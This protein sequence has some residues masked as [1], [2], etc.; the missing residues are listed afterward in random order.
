MFGRLHC[1]EPYLGGNNV[2]LSNIGQKEI[3]RLAQMGRC[4]RLD[5]DVELVLDV[6]AR[7][8]VMLIDCAHGA[9]L[10]HNVAPYPLY[11]IL[12]PATLSPLPL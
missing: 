9:T 1:F 5:D 7:S 12:L 2:L 3:N 6:V 10:N 4:Q 11:E 8:G